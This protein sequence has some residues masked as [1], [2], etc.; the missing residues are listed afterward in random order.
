MWSGRRIFPCAYCGHRDCRDATHARGCPKLP[1][2]T[3]EQLLALAEACA[4][5]WEAGEAVRAER[6]LD[7]IERSAHRDARAATA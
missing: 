7:A 1:A 3:D 4:R 2:L 6:R 5:G